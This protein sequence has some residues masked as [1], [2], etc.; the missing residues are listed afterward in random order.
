M[1]KI[2]HL[3]IIISTLFVI[4]TVTLALATETAGEY[5]DRKAEIWNL[6]FRLMIVAFT[7]GGVIAGSMVWQVWRFRESNPKSKPTP[8]EEKGE[9]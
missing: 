5:V 3:L 2:F 4:P 6:F 1:S 8:Y 9:L 7:V